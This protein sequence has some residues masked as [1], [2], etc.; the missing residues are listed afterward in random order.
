MAMV[1]CDEATARFSAKLKA[2]FFRH[3]RSQNTEVD[4]SAEKEERDTRA[5]EQAAE[6]GIFSALFELS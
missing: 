2:G 1:N 5:I 6:A 4:Y 3:E